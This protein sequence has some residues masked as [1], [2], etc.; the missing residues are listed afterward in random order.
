MKTNNAEVSLGSRIFTLMARTSFKQQD[1]LLKDTCGVC[2]RFA[3]SKR[4]VLTLLI[5]GFDL[6]LG[7][8]IGQT[9]GSR[10]DEELGVRT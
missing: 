7:G 8:V 1:A 2:R 4:G 9:D 3:I 5:F 6:T 10:L